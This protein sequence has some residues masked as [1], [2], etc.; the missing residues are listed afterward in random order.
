[1][2]R[3][4][5]SAK[6]CGESVVIRR[7]A[8]V[9]EVYRADVLPGNSCNILDRCRNRHWRAGQDSNRGPPMQTVNYTPCADEAVA[10]PA[11]DA[12]PSGTTPAWIEA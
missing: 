4:I 7:E 10:I 5:A 11:G 8:D 1:L 6:P 12:F 3:Y 2:T 9:R